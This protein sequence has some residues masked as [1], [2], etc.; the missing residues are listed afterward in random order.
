MDCGRS[1]DF[2]DSA[3][4]IIPAR[5]GSKRIKHKNIREMSGA[6][7]LA[8]T[9][10]TAISSKTFERVVVTTD[11]PAIAQIAVDCGAEV[12]FIRAADLA[13]DHA[14]TVDVVADAIK[15]IGD[16]T[17]YDLVCC[18]YPAAIFITAQDLFESRGDL[19]KTTTSS[20]VATVVRYEHPVQ[21][22]LDM[23]DAAELTFIDPAA[24]LSRTQD[25]AVRWHDAGQFYWGY[26]S[27][28]LK[29]TP[30]LANAIG[31]EL[32]PWR[33]QDIDTESDWE[34]AQILHRALLQR[35]DIK[36][37]KG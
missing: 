28:W 35:G 12:P 1:A 15:R 33:V 5:G 8:W 6:P 24:A 18:L 31:F 11:D 7:L 9:V 20:Y 14:T 36:H 17:R 25:L 16:Q 29:G 37:L 26:T 10:R 27:A 34:K 19:Q 30:I 22:A 2:S 21:R 23:N 4:A 13:N 3:L 32:P